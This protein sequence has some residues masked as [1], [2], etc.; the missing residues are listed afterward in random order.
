MRKHIAALLIVFLLPETTTLAQA[1]RVGVDP[2]VELLSIVCRLA[3]FFEY[4]QP[5]VPAAYQKAIDD[6]FGKYRDHKAVK[7]AQER[8]RKKNFGFPGP[9][10]LA[11]HL[12][13][14]QSLAERVPFE[15]STLA[16]DYKKANWQGDEIREFLELLRQFAADTKFSEF[17]KSQQAWYDKTDAKLQAFVKTSTDLE[18]YARFTGVKSTARF[19]V[20]P[21]MANGGCCYG[22]K[23][24]AE[25]GAEEVYAV[26][27]VGKV[28]AE[29]LPVFNA[30]YLEVMVHEFNHS[31]TNPSVSKFLKQMEK[32]ARLIRRH[33]S[34][35]SLAQQGY[36]DSWE[37]VLYESLVR[38]ATIRYIVAHEGQDAA[39]RKIEEETS[40]S[41][42]WVGELS[43]LLGEYEKDRKKY[44]TLDS[45]MPKVVAFFD[46]VPTRMDAYAKC[47]EVDT[48]STA[49]LPTRTWRDAAGKPIAE[50][51]FAGV[52]LKKADGQTE[53]VPLEKLSKEDLAYLSPPAMAEPH[54]LARDN[55]KKASHMSIG[56]SGSGYAIRFKADDDSSYVTSVSLLGSRY[57]MSQPP[58]EDF[59][60]WICDAQF[61]PIATFHF[62]YACYR[63]TGEE[64]WKTFRIWPTP[65][66][67]EF[68][69]CFG[70]N[71]GPTKGIYVS[72]DGQK[73]ET[74]VVGVPGSKTKPQPFTKGNWMIRCNVAGKPSGSAS[75]T[76]VT[77][78]GKAQASEPKLFRLEH[79]LVSYDGIDKA[80]ADAIARIIRTARATA[81]KQFGFDM[82]ETVNVRV[83]VNPQS[84]TMLWTDG[85][86]HVNLELRSPGDIRK[87][88]ACG[89][90]NLYGMCHE[91]G[92]IAMYR[93]THGPGCFTGSAA[94]SWA[95]Y[96]GSRVVEIVWAKEGPN[97]WP[98]RYEYIHDGMKRF[99]SQLASGN[100]FARCS[101]AWKSLDEI[102]GPKG[103]ASMFR[104]IG[105][106]KLDP[107]DPVAGLENAVSTLKTDEKLRKWWQA[108]QAVLVKVRPKSKLAAET[109]DTNKLAN[110]P[111]ELAHD[112]GQSAGMSS[113]AGGGHAVRFQAPDDSRYLTA[114]RIYGDRYG[115]PDPPKEDF[116]VWLCDKDFKAIVSFAYPYSSF[117]YGKPG[118]VELKTKPT[119]VPNKFIICV[120][121]NPTATKG[122]YAHYDKQGTGNS[123]VGLP[124]DESEPHDKGD[125]LIRCKVQKTAQ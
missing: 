24:T 93:L 46:G 51:Q 69:V 19:I 91:I 78:D 107:A 124:G 30:S 115:Y 16:A 73:G 26:C 55:G 14:V 42:F 67:R 96:Y 79:V 47:V 81:I 109:T 49:A 9:M 50:S 64:S 34:T 66:P 22:I 25:D 62:P 52:V 2:R 123:L 54:E 72:H 99:N 104:A 61:K 41:F 32:S 86:D 21:A 63:N 27:G 10:A 65:V 84:R 74:S 125:W 13:D 57:G 8:L 102:V 108:N 59:K 101:A 103:I 90:F 11:I 29:G 17:I 37:A 75:A 77:S 82:P 94:E 110:T 40:L 4:K 36:G 1:Y 56:G 44:P 28:D 33:K 85:Q 117:A 89:F 76:P 121:F 48:E 12:K 5:A 112:D 83:W 38:A 53:P 35:N 70:F 95:H 31:F 114:V 45:F 120:G 71:A 68:I 43:D 111:G 39:K 60:V 6:H 80:Y 119:R 122:I 92:H 58:R 20:I 98:D 97:L 3:D 18:W 106:A 116:H 23:N 88:A 87:P 105:N 15:K 100:E 118:W 113:I 7:F